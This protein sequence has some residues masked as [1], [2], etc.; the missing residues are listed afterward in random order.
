MACEPSTTQS[1]KINLPL[2]SRSPAR[3][4]SRTQLQV[5]SLQKDCALFSRLFIASQMRD[6]DIDDVF[7]HE[8]QTCPPALSQ[9]GKM[10]M[11]KKTDLVGCLEDMIPHKIML[12]V[13]MLKSSSL[14]E[15]IS[16]TCWHLVVRR[17]SLSMQHRFLAV[18]H[19]SATA[20]NQSGCRLG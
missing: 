11:G 8:N 6:G 4:K 9:M 13:L 16:P 1:R 2:F 14:M 3:E 15:H 5:S 7:A 19:I 17:P 20:C 18:H 10:R 12:L